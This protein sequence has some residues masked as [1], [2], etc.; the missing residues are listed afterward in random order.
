MF[1]IEPILWLQSFDSPGISW[2]MSTVSSLGYSSFYGA[3]IIAIIFG[4]K[5]KKGLV[6]F[7]AMVVCGLL[8]HGM[9]SGLKFPRPSDI[10]IRIFEPGMAPPPRL[11]EKGGATS[12]WSL[13]SSEAMAAVKRQP[14]WSY[15]FPSG[16][17]SSAA[18]FFLGIAFFFRW[19]AMYAFSGIWLNL[20]SLSRMYLGRHFIADVIAG[21]G[22]GV[23]AIFIVHHFVRSFDGKQ[24]MKWKRRVHMPLAFFTI[25]TVILAL[26]YEPVDADNVGRL[27]GVFAAYILAFKIHSDEG[28]VGYRIGRVLIAFLLFFLSDLLIKQFLDSVGWEDLPIAML[29]GTFLITVIPLVSTI[30]IAQRFNLYKSLEVSSV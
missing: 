28:K 27:L 4:L 17:V 16:H 23:L 21:V 22:V 14:Y 8:T 2:L 24:F 18:V 11:V 1:Q 20:M 5:L 6:I 29:I 15:G 13:P 9:K 7:M 30:L 19:K 12:F 25:V 3:L 26:I 10:D